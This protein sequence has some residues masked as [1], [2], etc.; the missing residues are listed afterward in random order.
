MAKKASRFRTVLRV[1]KHQEKVTQQQLMQIQE[2]HEQEQRVLARL[3]DAHEE[4]VQ[5]SAHTGRARA[6]DL[7]T[8]RAFIFKLTRQINHQ[9]EKVDEIREKEDFKRQELTERA[10]SRQMV[11]NLDEKRE[12]EVVR[13]IDRK[14]QE[15]IDELANRSGKNTEEK[16]KS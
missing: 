10:Q 15:M 9:S 16:W 6:T 4:A 13:S 11:E 8:Q 12:A 1:K 14:E 2:A 7:Q 3:H 5:E